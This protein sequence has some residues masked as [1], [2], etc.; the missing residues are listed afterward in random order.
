M[1]K[2]RYVVMGRYQVCTCYNSK[3]TNTPVLRSGW[4]VSDCLNSRMQCNECVQKR[5]IM[6]AKIR[7]NQKFVDIPNYVIIGKAEIR[8]IKFN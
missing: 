6:L 2:S 1:R 5:K 3:E 4:H 8:L 7:F